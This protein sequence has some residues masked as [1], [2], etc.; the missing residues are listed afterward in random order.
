MDTAGQV[1]GV[2]TEMHGDGQNLNLAVP[3]APL[4]QLM[5]KYGER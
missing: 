4:I 5:H 1:V 2:L 3:I